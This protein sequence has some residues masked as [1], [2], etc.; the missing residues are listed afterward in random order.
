MIVNDL[1]QQTVP[2][3]VRSDRRCRSDV[4]FIGVYCAFTLGTLAGTHDERRDSVRGRRAPSL[5]QVSSRFLERRAHLG[6]LRSGYRAGLLQCRAELS[7]PA[8]DAEAR[9]AAQTRRVLDADQG[10]PL[11]YDEEAIAAYWSRRPAE[12]ARRLGEIST[13]LIPFL[14]STATSR[15]SSGSATAK[16]DLEVARAVRLREILTELGPTF[17]KIGQWLAVRPDL[18]GPVTMR[19]LQKLHDAVPPFPTAVARRMIEEELGCPVE[20]V[21]ASLTPEPVAAASLGQVYRGTLARDPR[22]Q[23][24]VKVQRPDMLQRVSLDLYCIRHLAGS[25]QGIQNLFTANRTNFIALFTQ[26]ARGMYLE[27]DYVNEGRNT[28]RFERLLIESLRQRSDGSESRITA[29]RVKIP[30]VYFECTSRRVLTS[31]WIDGTKLADAPPQ[32]VRELVNVGV[33][34]FLTQLLETG[35]FHADPHPGN[36]LATPDGK[37]VILD[38]GLMAEIARPQMDRMVA[39]IIHLANR[40]FEAVVDDFIALDFLPD[41]E[42]VQENRSRIVTVMGNI[43][44]QALEGGGA[45]A[46]DFRSLSS[47]LA[48]VTFEFPFSIP[49][50]FALI[51]RALGVLEGIA[52]KADPNF[53]MIMEALPFVSRRVMTAASADNV[54]LR[55]ALRE[56]LYASGSRLRIARLRTLISSSQG[57][58]LEGKA[59]VDFDSPPKQMDAETMRAALGFVLASDG[60]KVLREILVEEIVEGMELLLDPRRRF[61]RSP[62]DVAKLE[63]LRELLQFI[64]ELAP[65]LLSSVTPQVTEERTRSPWPTW[66]ATSAARRPFPLMPWLPAPDAFEWLAELAPPAGDLFR[67]IV[68]RLAE[69]AVQQG[70]RRLR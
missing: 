30:K 56:I 66:R 22:R 65:T 55:R 20:Q 12:V 28:E 27:L 19:E 17:I 4:S 32:R 23:V 46:I 58:L 24:A 62:D 69:R 59:F 43:L 16:A 49:P 36:L 63:T 64:G 15:L 10:L 50:Y 13:L 2:Y 14:V 47:D 21:F 9:V 70:F 57:L 40:D 31:E 39:S 51:I 7:P 41:T 68:G 42:K 1:K 33:E 53:K 52:L 6:R 67:Q 35:F 3:A 11:V 54:T 25:A 29:D 60:G 8:S 18:V 44:N 48:A 38:F 34:C 45:R 26:W 37:L 5:A 61:E